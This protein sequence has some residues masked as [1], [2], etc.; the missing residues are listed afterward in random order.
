MGAGAS[1][2]DYAA[3][4]L[5]DVW[6]NVFPDEVAERLR[7]ED[8]LVV[9]ASDVGASVYDRASGAIFLSAEDDAACLRLGS[10][11]P[12][13]VSLTLTAS[14]GSAVNAGDESPAPTSLRRLALDGVA[15]APPTWLVACP[16]LMDVD[17]SYCAGLDLAALAAA[18]ACPRA[19]RRLACG[20]CDLG[21][22]ALAGLA[23]CA[24]LVAFLAP[25]NAF[26]EDDLDAAF[27]ALAA[28]PGLEELDLSD[29]PLGDA[30][31]RRY[32]EA[33]RG[34]LP[35]LRR[36]DGET[37][38]GGAAK[39]VR[40]LVAPAGSLGLD[41]GAGGVLGDDRAFGQLEKEFSAAQAGHRDN[42]AVA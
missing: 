13:I 37:V 35:R 2:S 7:R 1:T 23:P 34:A 22:A 32:R 12:R 26:A 21:A 27:A 14:V 4:P 18:L 40:D 6:A 8:G 10:A 25:E 5:Y 38:S 24:E 3:S 19:L 31:G 11:V 20:G 33:A 42:V 17:V 39:G 15:W 36:F 16:R 41:D 29:S 28:C 9:D 30:R